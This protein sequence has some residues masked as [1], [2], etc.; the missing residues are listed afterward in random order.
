MALYRYGAE[1][2]VTVPSVPYKSNF[3]RFS[4]SVLFSG[5]IFDRNLLSYS[6]V[7]VR[8]EKNIK[9]YGGRDVICHNPAE[10]PDITIVEEYVEFKLFKSP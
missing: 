7:R 9:R 6:T 8:G 10:F 4:D 3:H 2:I 1:V 5:L